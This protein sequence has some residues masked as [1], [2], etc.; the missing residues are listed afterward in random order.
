[1]RG[2]AAVAK[3]V[4]V[5]FDRG[6]VHW[7]RGYCHFLAAWGELYLALDAQ[8]RFDCTAHHFFANVETPHAFLREEKLRL[9]DVG[10]SLDRFPVISDLISLF[11]L[12]LRLPIKEP[13]RMKRVLE[14]LEGMVK[15]GKLMWK[16][17]LAETDDDHEWI[18]NPRQ[19]SV[20]PVRVTEEMVSEWRKTLDEVDRVL[21]GEKLLPFWRGSLEKR[22]TR[23]VDLRRVFLAPPKHLDI[24][25]WVQGTAATPY[26]K[27]GRITDLADA[28]TIR[29][30]DRTFGGFAFFG[31]AM[32]FN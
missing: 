3:E 5:G 11:H 7:L 22:G 21:S 8:E 29:R 20:L 13:A 25:Q 10:P 14:N 12:S 9:A 6:D 1:M 24:I 28:A 16:H 4:V 18:P 2:E 32:W 15:N 26:L 19:N 31:F 23:G 27:D 30:L 17:I